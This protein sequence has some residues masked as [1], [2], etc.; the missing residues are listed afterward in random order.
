MENPYTDFTAYEGQVF[1]YRELC[2]LLHIE[3]KR[4]KAKELQ[5]NQLRVYMDLDQTTI[6]RKIILKKIYPDTE[7]QIVKTRGK[8]YPYIKNRL[9]Q[10]LKEVEDHV[11]WTYT[12]LARTLSIVSKEYMEDRYNPYTGEQTIKEKFEMV[13]IKFLTEQN[14]QNF[15]MMTWVIIKEALRSALR[16]MEDKD[17]IVVTRC[18]RLFRQESMWIEDEGE[19]KKIKYTSHRDITHF[20]YEEY[21]AAR[22]K[23]IADFGLSDLKELFFSKSLKAA[24]AR[25]EFEQQQEKFIKEKGYESSATLFNIELSEGGK[26]YQIDDRFLDFDKLQQE[27]RKKIEGEPEIKKVIPLPIMKELMERYFSSP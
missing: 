8:Y 14:Y 25:S 2:D 10:H 11:A 1:T 5:L 7:L 15:F 22:D 4:G 3:F 23:I 27:L 18:L 24:T 19:M 26:E 9:L 21:I 12:D 20:E 13:G 17:L 6:P 16:Q